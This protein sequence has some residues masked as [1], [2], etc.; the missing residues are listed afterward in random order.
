MEQTI[1][2]LSRP[3]LPPEAGDW[4]RITMTFNGVFFASVEQEFHG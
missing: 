1:E 4:V 3:G 2:N